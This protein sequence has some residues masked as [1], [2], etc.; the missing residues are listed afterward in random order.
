MCDVYL[1]LQISHCNKKLHAKKEAHYCSALGLTYGKRNRKRKQKKTLWSRMSAASARYCARS[2]RVSV[3][4]EGMR[5]CAL[6]AGD[7]CAARGVSV[8]MRRD[9]DVRW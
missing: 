7:A 6:V 1:F 2:A 8:M 9:N 4:R 3:V 5:R